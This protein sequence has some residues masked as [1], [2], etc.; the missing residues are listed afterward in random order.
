MTRV[1]NRKSR[2][3]AALAVLAAT[4][5]PG[6]ASAEVVTLEQLEQLALE[7][8]AHWE[9]AEA[10][11]ERVDAE[12]DAARAELRPTF[13]L[14]TTAMVAPGS[15]IERVSTTDGRV[16]N[17]RASP[18][19]GEATAFRPNVRYDATIG[20]R[21]PLYSS[22]TRAAVKAAEAYRAAARASTAASRQDVLD[23]VRSSYLDWLM[24]D[25]EHDFAMASKRDASERRGRIADR[26]R[27]GDVPA[28]ELDSARY[29][30]LQ[31][32]LGAANAEARL[33]GA[34]NAV[35]LAAGVELAPEAEPDPRLLDIEPMEQDSTANWEVE[36]LERQ[37]DAV[38]EEARMHRK[39][40]VPVLAVIGQTGLTGINDKAFPMYQVGVN[41]AVP[42]WDGGKAV[43]LAHA[44]D[45]RAMELEA[46]A[47]EAR[48][49][50]RDERDQAQ[51]DRVH[52]EQRLALVDELVA[53][54]ERR[55]EQM[56]ERYELGEASLESIEDAQAALRDA[57]SRRVQIRIVRADAIL[58]LND[59]H[60]Q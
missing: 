55:V 33:A 19:V 1:C 45:A 49:T 26:V 56:K 41:L 47:R 10:T 43:A 7:N 38:R 16:V 60:T 30:E 21:A 54:S 24:A 6:A 37:G 8:Q 58:R 28:S 40:R 17:V 36:A 53:V 31:A 29:Q 2:A 39:T 4:I 15:D 52:A 13:L 50:E 44:A 32:E 46:R 23:H 27:D 42:L 11:T 57:R 22:Q 34:R 48:L 25:R 18:T 59:H 14:D 35:E 9:V 51:I 12:V 5:T 20:M 3:A